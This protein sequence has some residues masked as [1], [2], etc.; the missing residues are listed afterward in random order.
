MGL[1]HQEHASITTHEREA[2]CTPLFYSYSL[3]RSQ[4]QL[5]LCSSPVSG[6]VPGVFQA[7]ASAGMRGSLVSRWLPAGFVAAAPSSLCHPLPD[8]V[9]QAP[10]R[11]WLT[12]SA[13]LGSGASSWNA[14]NTCSGHMCHG[15]GAVGLEE[16][17]RTAGMRCASSAPVP[18]FVLLVARVLRMSHGP[19]AEPFPKG[20]T[21]GTETMI[22]D[23]CFPFVPLSHIFSSAPGTPFSFSL[24]LASGCRW[25]WG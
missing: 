6:H 21:L 4:L 11:P 2:A 22:S 20:L 3:W 23:K 5:S 24:I 13:C 8:L 25:Q 7:R 14:P 9:S 10:S 12:E 19:P 18:S 17:C 15:G 16:C 1:Y